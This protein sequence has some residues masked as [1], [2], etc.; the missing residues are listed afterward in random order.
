MKTTHWI[1]PLI[2]S[3]SAGVVVSGEDPMAICALEEEVCK[4]LQ[5]GEK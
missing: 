5:V 2:F 4:M 3:A 1:R